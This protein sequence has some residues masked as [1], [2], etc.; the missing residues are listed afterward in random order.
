LIELGAIN[1]YI[2]CISDFNIWILLIVRRLPQ[3][4]WQSKNT[5]TQTQNVHNSNFISCQ[6]VL[7][8]QKRLRNTHTH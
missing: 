4:T 6:N 3:F 2:I 5:L 7:N 1:E 8:T